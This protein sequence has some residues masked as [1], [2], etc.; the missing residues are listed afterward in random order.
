MADYDYIHHF[1]A[2]ACLCK[3]GLNFLSFIAADRFNGLSVDLRSAPNLAVFVSLLKD[4]IGYPK[5]EGHR[6]CGVSLLK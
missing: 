5:K 6:A 1:H 2:A 4:V 3:I